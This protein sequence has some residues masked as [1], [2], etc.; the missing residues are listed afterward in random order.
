MYGLLIKSH[1]YIDNM[2][3]E[4]IMTTWFDDIHSSIQLA[5]HYPD[6]DVINCNV[7]KLL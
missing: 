7:V 4:L 5:C 3:A 6:N 2:H 1:T